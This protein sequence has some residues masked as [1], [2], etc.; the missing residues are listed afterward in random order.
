M[1]SP[2]N[3]TLFGILLIAIYMLSG[4]SNTEN[5][6]SQISQFNLTDQ[7]SHDLINR[8]LSNANIF[9]IKNA[10]YPTVHI[11][12]QSN[13]IYLAYFKEFDNGT[14][15]VYLS[16]ST[17]GGK[18]FIESI[19]VNSFDKASL[20]IFPPYK[21]IEGGDQ[22]YIEY[23]DVR[24]PIGVG[25]E[26]QEKY[27]PIRVATAY[28]NKTVYVVWK[29]TD[30]SR[31]LVDEG[32]S[33]GKSNITLAR[34]VDGG[35]SF[36]EI[37]LDDNGSSSKNFFDISIGANNNIYLTWINSTFSNVQ[38]G[39]DSPLNVTMGISKNDGA[40][41][42]YL[43]LD[44]LPS[45]CDTASSEYDGNDKVYLSWRDLF[46]TDRYYLGINREIVTSEY[47]IAD[48]NL[49]EYLMVDNN[50][51]WYPGECPGSG[52]DLAIDNNN[53]LNVVWFTG[54]SEGPGIYLSK[55]SNSNNSFGMPIPI[56]VSKTYMS[57]IS[58]LLGI[59]GDNNSWIVW[60]NKLVSPSTI[61]ISRIK[62]SPNN[63]EINGDQSIVR[64]LDYDIGTFPTMD[65]VKDILTMAWM[66]EDN[67][68]EV[69]SKSL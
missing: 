57:P 18:T 46:N 8:T 26:I 4:S 12:P 56:F 1:S 49:T 16:K 50:T 45:D 53:T 3:Y 22:R 52:S 69:V 39:A 15:D 59:D 13:F 17:D 19:K 5:A 40:T 35:K 63:K 2:Y 68:I 23:A 28:D 25:G 51:Q 9:E 34:S 38:Y 47:N 37:L 65:M 67:S 10:S 31:D 6:F 21:M 60:E 48:N 58:P 30:F 27:S 55:L 33:F 32:Y 44:D 61:A 41:F 14:A 20:P 66:T 43:V 42:E 7:V 54:A 64:D 11:D 29:R 36:Q 24:V 62:E